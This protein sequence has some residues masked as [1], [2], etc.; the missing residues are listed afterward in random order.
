MEGERRG[1]LAAGSLLH[2]APQARLSSK[3]L[4]D[5][6]STAFQLVTQKRLAPGATIIVLKDDLATPC[7][8][9]RCLWLVRCLC[10]FI[11]MDCDCLNAR[12]SAVTIRGCEASARNFHTRRHCVSCSAACMSAQVPSG[13][14][15]ADALLYLDATLEGCLLVPR[16]DQTK[17]EMA[18]EEA[19]KLK[20]LQGSLRHL[21][22][23]SALRS[24]NLVSDFG[25][26]T[27]LTL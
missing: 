3:W 16:A 17:A 13:F 14:F 4:N 27:T 22:R 11:S 5:M 20:R 18:G 26:V 19:R 8:K 15:L 6:P 21:Y 9:A 12:R 24:F 1:S 10:K 23:N 25:L 2:D 7:M